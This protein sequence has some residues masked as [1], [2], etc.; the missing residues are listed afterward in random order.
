MACYCT[1]REAPRSVQAQRLSTAPECPSSHATS[2]GKRANASFDVALHLDV[3]I[4]HR[5]IELSILLHVAISCCCTSNRKCEWN[6]VDSLKTHK[7]H[8]PSLFGRPLSTLPAIPEHPNA[9]GRYLPPADACRT[10]YYGPFLENSQEPGASMSEA[11]QPSLSCFTC[12]QV[13]RK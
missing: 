9:L 4:C 8:I 10:G 13:M 1:L 5:S 12:V 7:L 6:R 3:E 11:A 2:K